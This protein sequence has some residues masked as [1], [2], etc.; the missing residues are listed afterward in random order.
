MFYIRPMGEH[1]SIGLFDVDTSFLSCRHLC[2]PLYPSSY[3]MVILFIQIRLHHAPATFRSGSGLAEIQL[4]PIR[5]HMMLYPE[6]LIAICSGTA[7]LSMHFL[8]AASAMTPT[9]TS[10][11]SQGQ[12]RTV[13]QSMI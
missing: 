6:L 12:E 8:K 13:L 4:M 1:T 2:L 5:F 7:T 11:P 3:D 9:E 10:F